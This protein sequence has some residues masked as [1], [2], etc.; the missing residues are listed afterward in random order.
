MLLGKQKFPTK[1]GNRVYRRIGF[2]V[3]V[4]GTWL[5]GR[6]FAVGVQQRLWVRF[7]LRFELYEQ[8]R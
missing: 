3:A 1:I 6:V 5:I 2:P 4:R 7:E 8:L